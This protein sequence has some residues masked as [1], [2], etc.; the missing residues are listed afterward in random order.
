VREKKTTVK[1]PK[2]KK[3]SHVKR[4][5]LFPTTICNPFLFNSDIYNTYFLYFFVL[6]PKAMRLTVVSDG[7]GNNDTNFKKY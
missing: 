1:R 2:S 4:F 5:F 3:H 7:V 6:C